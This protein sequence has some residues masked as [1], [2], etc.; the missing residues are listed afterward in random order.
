MGK[1]FLFFPDRFLQPGAYSLP[2]DEQPALG[3]KGAT[4][5]LS[6]IGLE[7]L[8]EIEAM[9]SRFGQKFLSRAACET[10][11]ILSLALVLATAAP[12]DAQDQKSP[13]P[14][15]TKLEQ[16]A[17][18]L[19]RLDA[20]AAKAFD[21]EHPGVR[22]GLQRKL[23]RATAKAF[24]WVD[25]NGVGQAHEQK[26]SD[27]WANAVTEAVEC[28]WLL[29]NGR[30]IYLSPQP[31]LDRTQNV[32]KKGLSV[33]VSMEHACDLLLKHGTA[34]F[35]AYPYTGKPDKFKSD[36]KMLYRIIACGHVSPDGKPPTEAQLKEALALY[37]PLAVII[38]DTKKF[39]DF[40]GSG[41]L[42]ERS[43]LMDNPH[44]VLLVGWD[45]RKAK[46][47]AWRIR[48]SWPPSW[49]D[50]GYAWIEYGSNY[51]GS[52]A[53]W[54]KAQSIYYTLPN[55]E[56]LKLMTEAEPLTRWK[57]PLEIGKDK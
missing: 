11:T 5:L 7:A 57:S 48:N 33:G 23:P 39:N 25:Q 32:D 18:D 14:A 54:V 6:A 20:T 52:D 15:F 51:V 17:R 42:A 35:N 45:D 21:E 26:A 31:L 4:A 37:G 8:Q 38:N 29:R 34:P 28:S 19:L 22:P 56:F 53:I 3:T 44:A 12:A 1:Q 47:G 24:N 16:R 2:E 36:V 10:A 43:K 50:D 40:R 55:A 9:G 30:R 41:V 13:E 46:Q 27:C 49:G